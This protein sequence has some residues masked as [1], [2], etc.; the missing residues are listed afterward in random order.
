MNRQ[1]Q[2]EGRPRRLWDSGSTKVT[3][4]GSCGEQT[5]EGSIAVLVTCRARPGMASTPEVV[6]RPHLGNE[7][8]GVALT[9]GWVP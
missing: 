2:T 1:A 4:C 7:G 8:S 6:H 5:P 9:L 3:D